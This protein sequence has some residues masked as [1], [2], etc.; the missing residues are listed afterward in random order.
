MLKGLK[1]KAIYDERGLIGI[2]GKSYHPNDPAHSSDIAAE[3]YSSKATIRIVKGA[4]N[5][6]AQ[7]N[8]AKSKYGHPADYGLERL[9]RKKNYSMDVVK[10]AKNAKGGV[11]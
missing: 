10:M 3:S 5:R 7:R 2:E 9:R 8:V 11:K 6:V 4:S 1:G